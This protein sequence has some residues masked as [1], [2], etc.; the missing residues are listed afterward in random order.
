MS[1]DVLLIRVPITF[2]RTG[3]AGFSWGFLFIFLLS[4]DEAVFVVDF[5]FVVV[6][7]GF[8]LLLLL[9]LFL[10]SSTVP[11]LFFIFFSLSLLICDRLIS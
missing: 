8:L 7:D 11:L 2:V 6:C 9:L 5:V 4:G 1:A 3:D 10:P